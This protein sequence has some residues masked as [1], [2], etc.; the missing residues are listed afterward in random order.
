MQGGEIIETL[1]NYG[2]KM[3]NNLE[4]TINLIA[5]EIFEKGKEEGI[6]IGITKT[7]KEF[8]IKISTIRSK[9]E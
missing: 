8:E 7:C 2:V 1:K 9:I 4:N 6:K 3:D 5:Y